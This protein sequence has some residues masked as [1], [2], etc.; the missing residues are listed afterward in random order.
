MTRASYLFF[1]KPVIAALLAVAI[2]GDS[3]TAL[4]IV[5]ILVV[6]GSVLVEIFWPRL[7]KGHTSAGL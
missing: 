7:A 6:S 3:P 4:Q 1:L 2:L 5:A